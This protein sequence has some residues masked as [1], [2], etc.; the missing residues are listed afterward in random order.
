MRWVLAGAFVALVFGCKRE[1]PATARAP[2]LPVAQPPMPVLD[3]GPP[4]PS[5]INLVHTTCGWGAATGRTD[6][7]A[8]VFGLVLDSDRTVTC[9]LSDGGVAWT[10]EPSENEPYRQ[11]SFFR[12]L[13][14]ADVRSGH[15]DVVTAV[16]RSFDADVLRTDGRGTAA[17][18][19]MLFRA[20]DR[21]I[22]R[23]TRFDGVAQNVHEENRETLLTV[24]VDMLGR[25]RIDVLYPGIAND[26]VVN[27]AEV[28]VYGICS[29]S[30]AIRTHLGDGVVPEVVAFRIV[31]QAEGS[32]EDQTRRILRRVRHY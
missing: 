27:G 20:P 25:E 28:V 19:G 1:A 32:A 2:A 11:A 14:I 4:E 13:F 30:R 7:D 3:A 18:A 31:P 17:S 6:A 5:A 29:G 16:L 21:M 9:T 26:R 10:L 24:A 8:S 12:H 22:G 15:P 23:V